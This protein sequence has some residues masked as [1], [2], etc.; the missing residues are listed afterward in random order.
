MKTLAIASLLWPP[1]QRVLVAFAQ[2]HPGTT[3]VSPEGLISPSVSAEIERAGGRVLALESLL[4]DAARA[5]VD[6]IVADRARAWGATLQQPTWAQHWR[7]FPVPS[8]LLSTLFS[9]VAHAQL[10]TLLRLVSAMDLAQQRYDL[11]L[12]VL[13]E[14]MTPPPRALVAWGRT[15]GVPSVQLSHGVEL[16]QPYTV[17]ADLQADVTAVFGERGMEGYRDIGLD[18]SSLRITGNPAWD[19]Y[20]QLQPRR[21]ELRAAIAAEHGLS[22]HLPIVVFGTTWSANLTAHSDEGIHGHTLRAFLLAAQKLVR[23]GLTAQFVVKDRPGAPAAAHQQIPRLFADHGVPPACARYV[24]GEATP[25]VVG[26]DVMVSMQS[27][28]SI[29]A[30]MVGTPAVDLLTEVGMWLGPCFAADS[31]VIETEPATLAD[32]LAALL[33]SDVLRE[34]QRQRLARAARRY[35]VGVDGRATDRFLNLLDELLPLT[36]RATR[37]GS[38]TASR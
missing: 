7:D 6:Q 14:D 32:T 30:M 17:H 20:A 2:R 8:D 23:S 38:V 27:N 16:F 5:A 33:T 34:R 18:I 25:W 31:G 21:A 37:S 9:Q 26:A 35:N 4:N 12:I 19:H 10:P 1:N 13:N 3:I 36:S 11:R 24:A 29:E 15:H 22:P 28:L